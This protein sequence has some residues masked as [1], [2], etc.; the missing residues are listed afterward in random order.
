MQILFG[1]LFDVIDHYFDHEWT[2]IWTLD[3]L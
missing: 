2:V 1:R 3:D